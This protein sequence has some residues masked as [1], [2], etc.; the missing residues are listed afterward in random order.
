M[1]TQDLAV[2]G[3]TGFV[4]FTVFM[5]MVSP[6]NPLWS[7][8]TVGLSI[9]HPAVAEMPKRFAPASGLESSTK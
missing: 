2:P 6:C 1:R 8:K 4:D 5:V 9:A 3:C 7:E